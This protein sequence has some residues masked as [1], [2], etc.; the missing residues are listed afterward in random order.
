QRWQKLGETYGCKVISLTADY[1]DCPKTSA[2]LELATQ[3]KDAKAIFMQAN[4]T[5][6]GVFFPL[7]D[8]LPKL[9]KQF[10]GLIVIDAISALCAHEIKMDEWGIDCL[11]SG[12]QKGFGIPPG[13][14]FVCLS[15]RAWRGVSNRPRSYFDLTVEEKNQK[16]GRTAYTPAVSLVQQLA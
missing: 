1:G 13:L 16:E 10:D 3:H 8:I 6:T 7:H 12:S 14:A 5:S 11:V 2:I 9:R 4:E 15:E